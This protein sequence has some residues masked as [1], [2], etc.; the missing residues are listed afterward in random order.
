[1]GINT[2]LQRRSF[3]MN[4]PFSAAYQLGRRAQKP[5][6]AEGR[7]R[8]RGRTGVGT[9]LPVADANGNVRLRRDRSFVERRKPSLRCPSLR[10]S[11]TYRNQKANRVKLLSVQLSAGAAKEHAKPYNRARITQSKRFAHS[12][13]RRSFTSATNLDGLNCPCIRWTSWRARVNPT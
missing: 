7:Y 4:P 11:M 2:P 1:M 12:P 6:L 9:F 8:P 3:L 5:S 13:E 10:P